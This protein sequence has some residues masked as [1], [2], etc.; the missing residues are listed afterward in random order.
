MRSRIPR[1]IWADTAEPG[2]LYAFIDEK[3]SADIA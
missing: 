3:L 1:V 2:L